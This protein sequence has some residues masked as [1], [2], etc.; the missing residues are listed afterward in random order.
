LDQPRRQHTQRPTCPSFRRRRA[1]EFHQPSF[2]FA[3]ELADPDPRLTLQKR[4]G[5][6]LHGLLAPRF[7]ATRGATIGLG[8]ALIGPTRPCRSLI[9]LQQRLSS[10]HLPSCR[11][12]SLNQ[13]FQFSPFFTGQLQ[14]IL[15]GHDSVL[16][17]DDTLVK[18][19]VL[20]ENYSVTRY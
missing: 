11:L 1:G 9:A 7:E 20:P 15:L 10:L 18:R 2:L 19:T 8:D 12:S 17:D 5:S 14:H 4:Q 3:V 13:L 6:P 16:L